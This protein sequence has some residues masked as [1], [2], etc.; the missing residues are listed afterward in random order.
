MIDY[1]A[2]R[3]QIRDVII[4]GG[5]PLTSATRHARMDPEAVA[6]DSARRDHSPWLAVPVMLPQRID[7]ELCRCSSSTA[8][9]GSTCTSI[10]RA[11]SRRRRPPPATGSLR[12]GIPLN[13]QTVLLAGVN[14]DVEVIR[15]LVQALM[16]IKVRPYYLYK[17]DPVRGAR[18]FRTPS[19]RASRSS[20][21]CAD[22]PAAGGAGFRRRCAR[23]RRQDPD[24][25]GLSVVL[26]QWPRPAAQLSGPPVR[27][28]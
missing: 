1:I 6:E 8:R 17:C 23:R 12:G 19:R 28:R 14:D 4:S 27:L 13:N 21:P 10:I 20:R 9:S 26:S 3:R 2:E 16:R 24:P 7:A 25:A 15:S 18:P 11:R 5:D 22:T